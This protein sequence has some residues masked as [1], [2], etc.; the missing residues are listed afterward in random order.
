M[1]D[2]ELEKYS[3][4]GHIDSGSQETLVTS[5]TRSITQSKGYDLFVIFFQVKLGQFDA[6]GKWTQPVINLSKTAFYNSL[7]LT[8]RGTRFINLK[9]GCGGVIAVLERLT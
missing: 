3:T 8:T 6:G 7:C 4:A 5:I 9:W 1:I 2:E